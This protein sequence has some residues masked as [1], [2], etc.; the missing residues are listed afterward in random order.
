MKLFEL[1][2]HWYEEQV[3][4]LFMHPGDKT[5]EEFN[6]EVELLLF[7]YGNEYL[8]SETSWVGAP[9]WMEFIVP[10]MKEFGYESIEPISYSFF[11][12]HL[13]EGDDEDDKN[14]GKIVGKELLEK[15]IEH[16]SKLREKLNNNTREDY[17]K[18]KEEHLKK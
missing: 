3:S 14:W 17:L 15:A 9:D 5:Q 4:Y 11:G 18:I 6:A 2:W 10:K 1:H 8:E 13:I 12:A 7:K 16:N